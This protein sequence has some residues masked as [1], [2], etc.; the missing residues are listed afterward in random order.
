MIQVFG[1][2]ILYETCQ[3]L[4]VWFGRT[5]FCTQWRISKTP[6]T[7]T[8][9]P[10][11]A[12]KLFFKAKSFEYIKP[13]FE[14]ILSWVKIFPPNYWWMYLLLYIYKQAFQQQLSC[15]TNFW[16][17]M[18]MLYQDNIF[19]S[20]YAKWYLIYKILWA[21]YSERAWMYNM[22][23]IVNYLSSFLM[24]FSHFNCIYSNARIKLI[25]TVQIHL[26]WFIQAG[27]D[28]N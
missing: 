18:Y 8:N 15:H 24:L 2:D 22:R 25:L 23:C 19:A 14:A 21:V 1:P 26:I 7:R 10:I 3:I 4:T 20:Q 5:I 27:L 11:A 17:T 9:L 6:Q 16:C 28:K 13:V 12:L